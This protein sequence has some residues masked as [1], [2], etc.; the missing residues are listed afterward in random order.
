MFCVQNLSPP[1][2]LK[3]SFNNLVD[4]SEESE[5]RVRSQQPT[6][7]QRSMNNTERKEDLEIACEEQKRMNEFDNSGPKCRIGIPTQ[8]WL[9]HCIPGEV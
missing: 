5:S 2:E 6:I 7:N 1:P 4:C 9:P 3:S 8:Q